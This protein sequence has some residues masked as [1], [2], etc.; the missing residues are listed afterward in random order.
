MESIGYNLYVFRIMVLDVMLTWISISKII[1]M[2]DSLFW[3]FICASF[4]TTRL[5]DT[6][7][8]LVSV[9]ASAAEPFLPYASHFF[10]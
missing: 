4:L 10:S 8:L 7:L 6:V 3:V 2:T 5:S 1:Q 9:S